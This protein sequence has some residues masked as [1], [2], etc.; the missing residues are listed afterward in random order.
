MSTHAR[1]HPS[2]IQAYLLHLLS[3]SGEDLIA[4]SQGA[5]KLF[6]LVHVERELE[7]VT[8]D[9]HKAAVVQVY[10]VS[11]TERRPDSLVA[12]TGSPAPSS[13]RTSASTLW[14]LSAAGNTVHRHTC[15]TRLLL[16]EDGG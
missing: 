14:H 15:T 11:P 3:E 16:T 13:A 1:V 10:A 9:E 2:H 6:K 12:L 8:D 4:L 7:D 5:L